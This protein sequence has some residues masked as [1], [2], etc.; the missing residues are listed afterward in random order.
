M[1]MVQTNAGR[2]GDA[3]AAFERAAQIDPTNADAWVGIANAQMNGHRLDAA[4][5]ALHNAERLQPDRP[6]VKETAKRLQSLRAEAG[7]RRNQGH[8]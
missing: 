6:V 1:G 3:L 8:Q 7:T 5:D 2:G 4:A